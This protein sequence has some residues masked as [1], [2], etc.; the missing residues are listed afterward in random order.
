MRNEAGIA[1]ELIFNPSPPSTHTLHDVGQNKHGADRNCHNANLPRCWGR[2]KR[3]V[4]RTI[5]INRERTM[6]AIKRAIRN[7]KDTSAR[8]TYVETA[9][10]G[11]IYSE[12]SCRR[13][14]AL[15]LTIRALAWEQ[16]AKL[17]NVK[18]PLTYWQRN[19]RRSVLVCLFSGK[20]RSFW[21][22]GAIVSCVGDLRVVCATLH[23]VWGGFNGCRFVRR[24]N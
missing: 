22:D 23:Y 1:S 4:R 21:F 12:G 17:W 18:R 6:A 20:R 5:T 7:E 24:R 14:E 11:G 2:I 3:F 9:I 15:P 10:V 19:R 8:Y 16:W 13:S